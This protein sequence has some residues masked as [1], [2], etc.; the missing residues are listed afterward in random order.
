MWCRA[1]CIAGFCCS[2]MSL[3]FDNC[4]TKLQKM[5]PNAEGVLPY[6]GIVDVMKQVI[7]WLVAMLP[8][9]RERRSGRNVDR[10]PR[11]LLQS[12]PTRYDR[13]P[14][15]GLPALPRHQEGLAIMNHIQT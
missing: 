12:G 10:V 2:F 11:L 15:P 5:K 7:N 13:P 3:P 14:G 9:R 6:K 8:D 4:K 1:S